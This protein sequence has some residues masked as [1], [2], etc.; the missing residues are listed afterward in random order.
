MN[1]T[2]PLQ[3]RAAAPGR[4]P[5]TAW[6]VPAGVF[7]VGIALVLAAYWPSWDLLVSAWAGSET[8]SHGYVIA[9]LSAWLVW[10]QRERLGAMQP[11]SSLLGLAGL[12]ASILLWGLGE[13]SEVNVLRYVA[14]VAMIPSLALLCFGWKVVRALWFPLAYLFFMI[15]LGEGLVPWLMEGTADA[16][17]AALRLSGIPVLREGLHFSLPTGRWSVVEACSGL[18]YLV[19]AVVL[20]ALFAHLNYR[21]LWKGALFVLVALVLSI[22]ANWA[23]AYIIVMVGHY[24]NMRYGVGDDHVVYGWVFFGLVMAGIFWMGLRYS[25]EDGAR[26]MPVGGGAVAGAAAAAQGDGTAHVVSSNRGWGAAYAGLACAALLSGLGF[27]W[28]AQV[29]DVTPRADATAELACRLKPASDRPMDI[30]PA[31]SGA[32][33]VLQGELDMKPAGDS[34]QF[35]VAYF[36]R[37]HENG[38]L[39][40][41]GNQVLALDDRKWG[42]FARRD[43]SVDG[44][45]TVQERLV[46]ASGDQRLIWSWYTVAGHS[47]AGERAAKLNTL[48][49]MLTGQG[50]HSTVNVLIVPAGADRAA[51][52]ERLR[53]HA[54]AVDAAARALT[55]AGQGR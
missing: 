22:V 48:K 41:W 53:V 18:R 46:R 28:V 13:I 12:A 39:I 7:T 29:R 2:T 21:R 52:L 16:T 10:R 34:V 44:K 19:A 8:Y 31:F 40:R 14:V 9:P 36:A 47:T 11:S 49:A 32:S 43:V 54:L 30:Q 5:P 17:I 38:E 15:P 27:L 42:T 20:S 1:D 55:G 3:D 51:A 35:Y 25:D 37:Q 45:F 4:R 26:P 24:S 6:R 33:S 23:R 50:D